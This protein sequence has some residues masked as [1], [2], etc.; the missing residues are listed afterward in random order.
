MPRPLGCLSKGFCVVGPEG[1]GGPAVCC[2]RQQQ[3]SKYTLKL[4]ADGV[5]SC[6]L[7]WHQRTEG[8]VGPPGRHEANV[9]VTVCWYGKDGKDA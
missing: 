5:P 4:Q 9:K 6:G 2:G 7:G 3:H 8:E 1:G